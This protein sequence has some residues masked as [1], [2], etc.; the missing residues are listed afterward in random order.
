[1]KKTLRVIA[2]LFP[3]ALTPL[4]VQ[5]IA[6]GVLD[7]GGGEKDLVW[8]LP[9]FAWSLTFAISSFILWSRGWSLSRS[10]TRSALV[11]LG[12]IVFAALLLAAFGQLGVGGRY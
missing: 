10:S 7:L 9:W 8:V 1:M 4:L 5:L 12:V 3:L 11:G 6:N 2:A